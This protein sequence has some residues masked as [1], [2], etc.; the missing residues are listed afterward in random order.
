MMKLIAMREESYRACRN[1][2]VARIGRLTSADT[3]PHL[4]HDF[5]ISSI[6]YNSINISLI[7]IKLIL[8]DFL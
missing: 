8:L 6:L 4:I 2:V 7:I 1:S 3:R 5:A